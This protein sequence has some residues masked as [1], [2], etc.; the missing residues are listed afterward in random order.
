MIVE[1]SV[2]IQYDKADN[3]YIASIPELPGCIA[4]GD[5]KEKALAELSIA[6]DLWIETALDVG[7]DIPE[8]V[9]YA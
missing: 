6:R 8:P 2:F 9:C 1:Y 3:I 7:K 5:T 4:H